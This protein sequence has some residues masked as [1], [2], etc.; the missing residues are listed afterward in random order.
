MSRKRRLEVI[1]EEEEE[2]ETSEEKEKQG[3]P[4]KKP[5]VEDES[6]ESTS[7]NV[8]ESPAIKR[9]KIIKK[10]ERKADSS[11]KLLPSHIQVDFDATRGHGLKATNENPAVKEGDKVFEFTRKH[12]PANQMSNVLDNLSFSKESTSDSPSTSAHTESKF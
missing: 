2:E 7:E 10:P 4:F 1:V 5:K 9:R 12:D 6:K 8:Q 11:S 3:K